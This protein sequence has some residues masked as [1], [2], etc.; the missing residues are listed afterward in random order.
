MI[1]VYYFEV[2]TFTCIPIFL[3]TK[4]CTILKPQ[5]EI[6]QQYIELCIKI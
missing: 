6:I 1:F 5:I 4:G 3:V 2:Q